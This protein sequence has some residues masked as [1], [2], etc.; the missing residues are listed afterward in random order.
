MLYMHVAIYERR[1]YMKKVF[2]YDILFFPSACCTQKE[3]TVSDTPQQMVS[4]YVRHAS[5]TS[6]PIRGGLKRV[7]CEVE[8]IA[9]LLDDI[10]IL[11]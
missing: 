2:T 7:R 10:C 8:N 11:T 4:M 3:E 5:D 1:T 6:L 9:A